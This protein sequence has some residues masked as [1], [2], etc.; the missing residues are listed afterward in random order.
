MYL[1]YKFSFVGVF[2]SNKISFKCML[3][4]SPALNGKDCGKVGS[5]ERNVETHFPF[6]MIRDIRGLQRIKVKFYKNVTKQRKN[7]GR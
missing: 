3:S 6:K 5:K 1:L 2:F 4:F 7:D